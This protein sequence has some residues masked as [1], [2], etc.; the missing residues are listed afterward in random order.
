MTQA[1]CQRR[2]SRQ[3]EWGQPFDKDPD[4]CQHRWHAGGILWRAW[5]LHVPIRL[6]THIHT[7]T[8]ASRV[9]GETKRWGLGH[10]KENSLLSLPFLLCDGFNEGIWIYSSCTWDAFSEEPQ[11]IN[12]YRG[13][14]GGAR[15]KVHGSVKNVRKGHRCFVVFCHLTFS[16]K[17]ETEDVRYS[18]IW[19]FKEFLLHD[20]T[21]L[22]IDSIL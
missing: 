3:A 4:T 14:G 1:S 16:D 12:V 9:D 2:A 15:Q 22:F 18:T 19:F 7:V 6:H 21:I 5:A 17:R 8:R 10:S 11:K 13:G 20:F